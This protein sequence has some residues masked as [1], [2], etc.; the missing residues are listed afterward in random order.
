MIRENGFET[1]TSVRVKWTAAQVSRHEAKQQSRRSGT[2][3]RDGVGWGGRW[4]AGLEWVTHVRCLAEAV[5]VLWC[6]YPP[7]KLIKKLRTV[8]S[9]SALSLTKRKLLC[10][11]DL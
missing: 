2:T 11:T 6:S 7:I 1:C 4:G 10:N 8:K 5:T 9:R 3:Q